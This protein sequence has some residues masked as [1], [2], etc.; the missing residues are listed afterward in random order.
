MI[1]SSWKSGCEKDVFR[2]RV[3]GLSGWGCATLAAFISFRVRQPL[4]LPR[5]ARLSAS[6]RLRRRIHLRLRCFI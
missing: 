1:R 4:L 5:E 3:Y 6:S 2:R